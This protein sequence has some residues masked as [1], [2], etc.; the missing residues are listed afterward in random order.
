MLKE[1]LD[2]MDDISD[3]SDQE[4][5]YRIIASKRA[6]ID[7]ENFIFKSLENLEIEV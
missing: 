5:K 4:Q 3:Y 2:Y 1:I 7:V 6:S